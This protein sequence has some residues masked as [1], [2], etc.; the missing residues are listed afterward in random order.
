MNICTSTR[1]HSAVKHPSL[2]VAPLAPGTQALNEV[3]CSPVD[4]STKSSLT[5]KP[6]AAGATVT[7]AVAA[8]SFCDEDDMDV[9][10]H[11]DVYRPNP[12]R[13]SM[14]LQFGLLS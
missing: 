11:A 10:N 8:N 5:L 3:L 1:S 9:G 6:E 12:A 4:S 7:A 13:A 2:Q 14:E